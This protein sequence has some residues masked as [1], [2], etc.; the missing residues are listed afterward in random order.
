MAGIELASGSVRAVVG[1]S[2]HGRLHVSGRGQAALADGVIAAGVVADPRAASVAIAAALA[3]AEHGQRSERVILAVDGDDVRTYHRA[4]TFERE[5]QESAVSVGEALRATREAREDAGRSARLAATDDPALR[6]VA[7]AELRGDVC[8]YLLDGRPLG[9]LV[10]HRGR[11]VEVRT[12]VALAPLVLTGAATAALDA[13]RRRGAIVAGIYALGRL[14]VG[15][16]VA[17]AGVLRITADLTA[18]A[19]LRG[20]RVAATRSF[21]IGRETLGARRG[22]MGDAAVWARC[23]LA[24]FSDEGDLPARWLVAG[25]PAELAA[26]PRALAEA[27][28]ARRGGPAEVVPLRSGDAS[29]A[30]GDGALVAED[31]VAVGAAALAAEVYA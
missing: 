29:L 30:V 3:A 9:T 1:R 18:G 16:G 6:G 15:S 13:A 5:D 17:E 24:A 20:G 26:F 19:L 2:E 10:G 12:D 25:L 27:L 23:V 14:V 7:T 22:T 8:G 4:T 21:A 28:T 31:L 11:Y